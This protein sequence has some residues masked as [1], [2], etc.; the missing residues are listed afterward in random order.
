MYQSQT[1]SVNITKPFKSPVCEPAL[2]DVDVNPR[3]DPHRALSC[4]HANLNLTDLARGI[5]CVPRCSPFL[6]KWWHVSLRC[7]WKDFTEM[8]LPSP[9]WLFT[10]SWKKT[11]GRHGELILSVIAAHDAG[12]WNAL[13]GFFHLITLLMDEF[14]FKCCFVFP[15]RYSHYQSPQMH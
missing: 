9:G 8:R 14:I 2:I 10:E 5:M 1:W 3:Q 6:A 12:A 15:R 11:Q 4:H 7:V 13:R